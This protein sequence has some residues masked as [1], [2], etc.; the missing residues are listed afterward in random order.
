MK[1]ILTLSQHRLAKHV[2]VPRPSRL[3]V[4]RGRSA[5]PVDRHSAFPRERQ[6]DLVVP[7]EA[8]GFFA[9]DPRITFCSCFVRVVD[10][11]PSKVTSERVHVPADLR[12]DV[13]E[14]LVLPPDLRRLRGNNAVATRLPR[15]T[16][17]LSCGRV[18]GVAVA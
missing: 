12:D 7:V 5:I 3:R 8:R 10:E 17:R 15:E 13:R 11:V 1:L 18:D 2:R 14:V 4:E 9:H 6:G 16:R